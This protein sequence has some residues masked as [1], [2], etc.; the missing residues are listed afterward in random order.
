MHPLIRESLVKRATPAGLPKPHSVHHS[1][2]SEIHVATHM[3]VE[4]DYQ[5]AYN[6][7][8]MGIYNMIIIVVSLKGARRR[9]T[10]H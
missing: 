1:D 10:L 2:C 4:H 9:C 7:Y 3:T 5:Y 8:G 6:H